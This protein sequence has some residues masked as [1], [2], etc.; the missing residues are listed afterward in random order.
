MGRVKVAFAQVTNIPINLRPL[1]I[2]VCII[3]A[4]VLQA[5]L[6][7]ASDA[8]V[9]DIPVSQETNSADAESNLPFLFAAFVIVWGLFF[10]YLLIMLRR[11]RDLRRDVE[12]L[13]RDILKRDD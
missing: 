2:F 6:V 1:Y 4:H 7:E 13:R 8:G 11:G 5:P 10:G 9:A 3:L 12:E